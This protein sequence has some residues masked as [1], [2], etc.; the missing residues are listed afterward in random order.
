MK[1]RHLEIL[2]LVNERERISVKELSGL[3]TTSMVTI[4]KDMIELESEGLLQRQHGFAAKVSSDAIDAR[5]TIRYPQKM[6]IARR[7]ASLVHP[8]ETVMVESGSTC[9]LLAMELATLDDVTVITNS[10]YIA[11]HMKQI[12]T[13]RVILLGGIMM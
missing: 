13:G 8:G 5:M 1:E 10:A 6:E 12:P 9:A 7:A 11:R 2:R 3:L 4:R